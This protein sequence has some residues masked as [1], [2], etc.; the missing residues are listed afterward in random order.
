MGSTCRGCHRCSSAL[1]S[2]FNPARPTVLAHQ[3]N[4]VSYITDMER[5]GLNGYGEERIK[6][7][8]DMEGKN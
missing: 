3:K 6:Y 4:D 5:K 7:I 1:K 8:T 2:T